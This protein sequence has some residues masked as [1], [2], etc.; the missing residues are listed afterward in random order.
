MGT[1]VFKGVTLALTVTVVALAAVLVMSWSGAGG[2]Y[3]SLIIDAGLVLGCITAG[4]RTAYVTNQV[5]PGVLAVMAYVFLVMVLLSFYF[6]LLPFGALKVLTGAV[7]VAMVSALAGKG[8]AMYGETR[9]EP[10]AYYEHY[11]QSLRSRRVFPR[12]AS[13]AKGFSPRG[14]SPR[15]VSPRGISSRGISSISVDHT[16]DPM[17]GRIREASGSLRDRDNRSGESAG[18]VRLE[19]RMPEWWERG[20]RDRG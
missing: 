13:M 19:E 15:G 16:D 10:H 18:R 7:L 12:V 2:Q 17:S 5:L 4:Y 3:M 20:R 14:F 1:S 9:D 11:D 8:H 6:Q